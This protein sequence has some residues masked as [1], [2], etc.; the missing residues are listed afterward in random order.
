MVGLHCWLVCIDG[1]FAKMVSSHCWLVCI[2]GGC[3]DGWFALM[4]GVH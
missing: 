2:D 4:V 1:G 3:I